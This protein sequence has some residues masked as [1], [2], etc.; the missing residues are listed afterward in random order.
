MGNTLFR[1]LF[2]TFG[3][4]QMHCHEPA[5][6][7]APYLQAQLPKTAAQRMPSFAER[8]KAPVSA[9]SSGSAPSTRSD[10]LDTRA[11]FELLD[12]GV[13]AYRRGEKDSVRCVALTARGCVEWRCGS[14][15]HPQLVGLMAVVC[16]CFSC[17]CQ[18]QAEEMFLNVIALEEIRQNQKVALQVVDGLG[19]SQDPAP[20]TGLSPAFRAH[21]NLGAMYYESRDIDA[22]YLHYHS[23]L[24]LAP[25]DA[26]VRVTLGEMYVNAGNGSMAQKMFEPLVFVNIEGLH[27][28]LAAPRDELVA[29]ALAGMVQAYR[30]QRNLLGIAAVA[31]RAIAKFEKLLANSPHDERLLVHFVDLLTAT[32]SHARAVQLLRA[33]TTPTENCVDVF[34]LLSLAKL[35]ATDQIGQSREADSLYQRVISVCDQGHARRYGARASPSQVRNAL[36]S[37]L[38][39]AGSTV[40]L[41][42]RDA[43][44]SARAGSVNRAFNK[45]AHEQALSYYQRVM[46]LDPTS[47]SAFN[48]AGK[49]MLLLGRAQEAHSVWQDGAA[50][51][52][53][54]SV[55]QHITGTFIAGG[56]ALPSLQEGLRAQPQWTGVVGDLLAQELRKHLAT[57]QRELLATLPSAVRSNDTDSWRSD[58]YGTWSSTDKGHDTLKSGM[59]L[60]LYL[61]ESLPSRQVACR[62]MPQ[63]CALLERLGRNGPC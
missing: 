49:A 18:L 17:V 58:Y 61:Q 2:L 20:A 55:W 59:W 4:L 36:I 45:S 52:M 41:H 5:A 7:A 22:A 30:L 13:D 57:L 3:V 6:S 40:L 48:N 60:Q 8:G 43:A 16:V 14:T 10:V 50:R 46:Q 35:L 47:A 25:V 11:L 63:T 62:S 9:L 33:R 23:A 27:S 38:E 15:A 42:G 31:P 1:Q 54:P 39:E 32:D 44:N 21:Q 12:Q 34:L 19:A 28:H 29:A 51:G 24:E 53:W 56:Q 26:I 37:A